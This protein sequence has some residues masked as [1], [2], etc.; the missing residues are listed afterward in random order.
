MF[1]KPG[2]VHLY[3]KISTAAVIDVTAGICVLSVSM[4]KANDSAMKVAISGRGEFGNDVR[5]D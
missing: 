2:G 4:P 1:L 5:S 3:S